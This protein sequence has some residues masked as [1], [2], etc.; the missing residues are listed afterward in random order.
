LQDLFFQHVG[1]TIAQEI[2]RSRLELAKRML[3][4][5]PM[6]IGLIAEQCGLGSGV[7]L[8]KVFHREFN[9]TPKEYRQKNASNRHS[10][11][12]AEDQG[13]GNI[14]PTQP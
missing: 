9:I 8:S 6:K 4:E 5:S 12:T 1:R 14:Y 13:T 7:R 2:T 3:F 11:G 10:I